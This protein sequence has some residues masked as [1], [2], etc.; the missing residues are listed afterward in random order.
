M[1]PTKASWALAILAGAAGA[2]CQDLPDVGRDE[3]GN[4]VIEVGE[5]CEADVL[6]DAG[7]VVAQCGAAD[8]VNACFFEWT[9]TVDCPVGH[10]P[11]ADGRCRQASGRFTPGASVTLAVDDIA[12][13]DLDGDGFDDVIAASGTSI[14]VSFGSA[15]ADLAS[16]LD[17][18][19]STPQTALAVGDLDDSGTADVLVATTPGVQTFLGGADRS[20]DPFSYPLG[21]FQPGAGLL[22]GAAADID[23]AAMADDVVFAWADRV[24]FALAGAGVTRVLPDPAGPVPNSATALAA[25]LPLGR[26]A[27]SRLSGVPESA[28]DPSV[29]IALGF[30]GSQQI[31]VFAATAG[32]MA[33]T[34]TG[35]VLD[36]GGIL[37]LGSGMFFGWFD[38]DHCLDLVAHAGAGAGRLVVFRG[39]PSASD[40]TGA[41]RPAIEMWIPPEGLRLFGAADFDGDG[42]TD[43]VTSD[44]VY[45]VT[46]NSPWTVSQVSTTSVAYE[47]AEVVDLNGDGA[48]DVAAFR[49]SQPDVE[50]LINA[51]T[52]VNRFVIPTSDPVLR[53]AGGDFDG[54]LTPDLAIVEL[55][56]SGETPVYTV[57]VSFGQFHGPPG[58]RVTMD[59]FPAIAGLVSA[60]LTGSGAG[61]DAASDLIV[62]ENVDDAM[63]VTVLMGSGARAMTSPLV[64]LGDE[65]EM[66][67]SLVLGELDGAAGLDLFTIGHRGTAFLYSGDDAGGF[68][69]A[70]QAPWTADFAF[71]DALWTSGDVD[72]DGAGEVAAVE[73]NE[74]GPAGDVSVVV[75]PPDPAATPLLQEDVGGFAG[76]H[77]IRLADLD[78]DGDLDLLVGFDTLDDPAGS[79]RVA[80][81]AGGE[82]APLEAVPGTDGC[83]DAVPI[84]LD[85]DATPELVALCQSDTPLP[86]VK[87]FELR[88]FDAVEP[89]TLVAASEPIVEASGGRSTRLLAGDLDGDG[90]HDLVVSTKGDETAD[91]RVLIQSDVHD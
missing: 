75:F 90:L 80:W 53:L 21:S 28:Q 4:G 38:D 20:L 85:G 51:G 73:R 57:S 79:L 36:P 13:G 44:G 86:G 30:L 76:A 24:G 26:L 48:P 64:L 34:D 62:V 69:V 10:S 25:P 78:G 8:G 33:I 60:N 16:T 27:S 56:S 55:D 47:A 81:G 63:E 71:A 49:E 42:H 19:V 91:V 12:L 31:F 7:N 14:R 72:G 84:T 22:R 70:A 54:D 17:G 39:T 50:V 2:A 9:D 29:E 15:Q 74:R 87:R 89:E 65:F 37:N 18:Q 61:L 45:R 59:R 83:I 5:D 41:L 46:G 68:T 88:R 82:L 1:T 11:G 32:P 3:C 6:D 43:L 52:A 35:V 67:Q 58:A 23:P 40:C 66:P 77:A